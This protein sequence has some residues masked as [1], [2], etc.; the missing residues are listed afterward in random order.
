MYLRER[1][2]AGARAGGAEGEGERIP[3]RLSTEWGV[4]HRAT[5][6]DPELMTRAEIKSQM[7]NRLSHP[8]EY[9]YIKTVLLSLESCSV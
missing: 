9:L 7:L 3:S 2:K 6:Q 4:Q 5:S 1:E 8:A